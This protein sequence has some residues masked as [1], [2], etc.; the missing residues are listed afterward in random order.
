LDVTQWMALQMFGQTSSSNHSTRKEG[1]EFSMFSRYA[2]PSRL[3]PRDGHV[4][5]TLID[6]L[7][8]T[9]EEYSISNVVLGLSAYTSK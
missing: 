8:T 4:Y 9:S 6:S 5:E 2:L 7:K 3:Q 1:N